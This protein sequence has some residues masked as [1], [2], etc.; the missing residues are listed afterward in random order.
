M[1]LS[2]IK[3]LRQRL[4]G[5]TR[6]VVGVVDNDLPAPL[7]EVPD[8]LLAPIRRLLPQRDRLWRLFAYPRPQN[9]SSDESI[10]VRYG[11]RIRTPS[12]K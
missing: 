2:L 10:A 8:E 6:A 3:P 4:A 9:V 12:V 7:E 11:R 5:S 1:D